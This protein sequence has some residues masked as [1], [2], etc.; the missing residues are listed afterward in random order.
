MT[1]PDRDNV[2]DI[3]DLRVSFFTE[4]GET[5]AVDGVDFSMARGRIRALVGESGCGKSVTAF[6]IL[7]LV[8][9]PPAEIAADGIWIDGRNLLELSER[10]MQDVRGQ[11]I[12]MIFQEP[13]SS[14]NPVFTCGAQIVEAIRLHQRLRPARARALAV[15]ML[16]RVGIP[17]P[18]QRFGEYP[19]QMSG[20]M[21][22]RVMI[23]M[24]L[25]CNPRLLIADEPTTALD[26][27]IQ[28]EI[29]ELLRDLQARFRMAMLLITHD[30][31]VVRRAA[32]KVG[33]MKDGGIVETG[34]ADRVF[35]KPE[36][37]YTC[38]LLGSELN[39]SAGSGGGEGEEVIRTERLGVSFPILRGVFRTRKGEVRAVRGLSLVIREGR[40]V[41]LVGESGS[42]KTTCGLALLRLL[43]STGSIR[44]RGTELQGRKSADLRGL[45][46]Q[47][48]VI[49]Q[50]PFASLNPR[51]TVGQIVEE[52]LRVHRPETG[53]DER[54]RLIAASLE[55]V[56]LDPEII[57]RYPHEFSGGQR[58]RISIARAL[59]LKP[60]LLVLD[61]PTSSLDMS[62]QTQI[63]HLLKE[64]QAR[65]RLAYLFI[66][67]DLRVVRAISHEIVVLKDGEVVER[68][69]AE[70][71]F[72]R[73]RHTYTRTLI[74][75]AA[76]LGV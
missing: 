8:P 38:Y 32:G 33:V 59:I 48:Q 22:Q 31:G 14:L 15:E 40:T 18:A 61:E 24:A 52:G 46:R 42:G 23:A 5:R 9:T 58:Q 19:H 74:Q 70:R 60:R 62:V 3:Q 73:P 76:E 4:E 25:S 16:D 65:H 12:S 34:T 6:S 47:M 50:D 7:R 35:G 17:E 37:P 57:E 45:R 49:F 1:T 39:E 21:R 44:F 71:V 56:G 64:L 27:T 51:F 63:I 54:R 66:S 67:H 28:A 41:G 55:E 29:L 69:P 30:L 26:V 13:M 53:A 10:Q 11:Q 72:R 68:G 2:L 36:H 75:A 43:A 20:G